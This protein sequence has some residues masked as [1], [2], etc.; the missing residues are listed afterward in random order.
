MVSDKERKLCSVCITSFALFKIFFLSPRGKKIWKEK[1]AYW[2]SSHKNEKSFIILVLFCKRCSGFSFPYNEIKQ[3][4]GAVKFHNDTKSIQYVLW[5]TLFQKI[6]VVTLFFKESR[7]LAKVAFIFLRNTVE[8]V[9]LGNS[10]T[11]NF[12][13]F[14]IYFNLWESLIY[15]CEKAAFSIAITQVFSVIHFSVIILDAFLIIIN[16]NRKQ[17]NFCG[18]SKLF[19]DSFDESFIRTAFIGNI[20]VF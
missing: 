19:Q 11:M 16:N 5:A 20:C 4:S 6:G 2:N 9:T 13:Y 8:T 15:F 18:N 1:Q 14:N 7:M 3:W 12:F 10:I 17:W